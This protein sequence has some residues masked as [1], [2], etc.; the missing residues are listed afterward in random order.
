MSSRSGLDVAKTKSTGW[1]HRTGTPGT[2]A[3]E[4]RPGDRGR[5]PFFYELGFHRRARRGRPAA[6][7][8]SP[9]RRHAFAGLFRRSYHSRCR[10]PGCLLSGP[11][12][13]HWRP[14]STTKPKP[15]WSRG[16][17]PLDP[18]TTGSPTAPEGTLVDHANPIDWMVL[19]MGIKAY[20]P[21][22]LPL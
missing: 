12:A 13:P 6:F 4:E 2:T 1:K 5:R 10:V 15:R 14:N 16:P 8:N 9:F 3:T 11:D 18:P 20:P 22:P 7:L 19:T 17:K 21:L